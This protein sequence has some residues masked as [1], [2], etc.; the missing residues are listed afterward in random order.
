MSTYRFIASRHPLKE[1]SNPHVTLLSY[2]DLKE[3]KIPVGKVSTT[4]ET[5]DPHEKNF[6]YFDSDNQIHDLEIRPDD[7]ELYARPYTEKQHISQIRWRYNPERAEV[8]IDYIREHMK[9]S[10]ADEVELWSIWT[11][12]TP[13]ATMRPISLSDLTL[14]VIDDLFGKEEIDSPEGLIITNE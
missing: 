1:L 7:P 13:S 6:L 4:F 3:R 14:E 10:G 9:E 5:S 2:Q 8:L 12:D 11:E